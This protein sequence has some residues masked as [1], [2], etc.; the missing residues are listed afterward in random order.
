MKSKKVL[1]WTSIMPLAAFPLSLIVACANNSTS[2][3]EK[4]NEPGGSGDG[5]NPGPGDATPPNTTPNPATQETVAKTNLTA[6]MFGFTGTVADAKATMENI[7]EFHQW[8]FDNRK[9]LLDGNTDLFK[10]PDDIFPFNTSFFPKG[11]AGD[12]ATIGVLNFT[13]RAG[14]ALGPD[15][16]PTTADKPFEIEISGF[17]QPSKLI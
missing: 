5:N 10:T 17:K 1:W 4:P 2:P 11:D 13:L 16:Q 14:K 7:D 15:G 8:I 12:A 3:T 9:K 6:Q